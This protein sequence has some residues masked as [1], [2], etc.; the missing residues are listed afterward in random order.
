[1]NFRSPRL[2]KSPQRDNTT[3]EPDCWLNHDNLLGGENLLC[4]GTVFFKNG[5][6]AHIDT[7]SGHYEPKMIEHLRPALSKLAK[8]YPGALSPD[9]EI[10]NF[11]GKISMRYQNFLTVAAEDLYEGEG[12]PNTYENFMLRLGQNLK[13]KPRV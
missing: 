10:G 13:F 1:V 7:N 11:N 9:T 2:F 3:I 8:K 12:R 6:I 4:A 5:K